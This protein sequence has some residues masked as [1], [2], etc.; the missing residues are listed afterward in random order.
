[1]HPHLLEELNK[2]PDPRQ[3]DMTL[4]WNLTYKWVSDEIMRKIAEANDKSGSTSVTAFIQK[5]NGTKQL[6]VANSGDARCV[7][8]KGGQAI[9]MSKDHKATDPEEEARI[10]ARGGLVLMG[11]VAATLAVARAFGDPETAQWI[12]PEPTCNSLELDST[13][14]HM[15]VACDGL[16]DVC[17]DQQVVEI[18]Q[19]YSVATEAAEA[20]IQAA[21]D[22]GTKDNITV[23]V[24][25]L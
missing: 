7:V 11:K 17:T 1:M 21:L 18:V 8:N 20:L 23:V 5:R 19:K 22:N 13:C 25:F 12:T 10:R 16:W 4:I 3:A 15:I 2:V 6:Y 14:T 24:I 9:R